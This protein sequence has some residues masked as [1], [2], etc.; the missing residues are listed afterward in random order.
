[1]ITIPTIPYIYPVCILL[2]FIISFIVVF[3]QNKQTNKETLLYFFLSVFICSMAGGTILSFLENYIKYGK[4]QFGLSSYGGAIGL[5]I[6]IFLYPKFTS[7]PIKQLTKDTVLSLPLIYGLSKTACFFNG[8]CYGFEYGGP[9]SVM[10][11]DKGPY[12]PVQII[13]TFSFVFVYL[14]IRYINKIEKYE[15]ISVYLMMI[16]AGLTKGLLDFLRFREPGISL[17]QVISILFIIAGIFL[18]IRARR[19]DPA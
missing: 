19:K 7:V 3:I 14:V 13:E 12:F 4:F 2:S 16:L 5:L 8:C 17:N 11:A 10:Y 9:L 6:T 1:M 18:F 15:N